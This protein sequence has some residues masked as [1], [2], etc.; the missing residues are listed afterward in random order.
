M[1]GRSKY[2]EKNVGILTISNF[3]SKLLVFLLVPLYTSVLS[4]HEAGTYDLVVST[5][6]LLLPILTLN[7][8]DAVMRFTMDKA[9]AK[10]E[11]ASIGLKYVLISILIFLV[12]VIICRVFSIFPDINSYYFFIFLYFACSTLN[13]YLIQLAKGLEKV[14]CM[15][16]AGII[17][18]VAM[19]SLNIL[20]QLL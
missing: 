7:I 11:V 4:T 8:V 10:N 17:N 6:S 13:Q 15:A 18:T 14:N 9:R 19:L 16:V 1:N 5:C 2:L 3:G 12:G 20:F